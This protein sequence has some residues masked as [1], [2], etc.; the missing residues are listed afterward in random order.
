[1]QDRFPSEKIPDKK[2]LEFAC[3]DSDKMVSVII[4]IDLPE[5]TVEFREVRGQG[6]TTHVP[7]R[8]TPETPDERDE[9]D[10][11][12][13]ESKKFLE[14]TLGTSAKWLRSAHAFVATARPAQIR[15]IA[16]FPLTK[17]IR[18]SRILPGLKS[19]SS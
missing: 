13:A 17:V 5:P 16:R 6:R 3:T 1:M 10:R 18:A 9:V 11:K 14:A 7:V 4:E 15:E 19:A 2:F 12:T 8:V